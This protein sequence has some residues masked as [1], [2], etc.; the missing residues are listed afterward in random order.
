[1]LLATGAAAT[2]SAAQQQPAPLPRGA[3]VQPLGPD[4]GAELR[5][6]LTTLADNP[7]SLDALIGAGRAANESGDAEA[8]LSFFGRADELSPRNP[9]IK[10]G[11]AS[12]L[13]QM[14][15]AQAALNLF[16]QAIALGAPEAE[17]AGDRGLAYDMIG[18]PRR[19]QRD[20]TLALRR[21]DDAELRRRLALSL[22][23]SGQRDA[24]LRMID[25][26]LRRNDRAAWRTQAFVLALTGD[27][28]GATRTAQGTMPPG[29]AA[30]MAPFLA[31]LVVLSPAQKAMAV[32]F[33][34]FP[35][36]G[37]ARADSGVADTSADPGAVAL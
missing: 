3:V 24:A 27:A 18:D 15:R 35:S 14:G 13:V 29:A 8:A 32:H 7:R 23:I 37:R 20:Y 22:A 1:M 11:M 28:A 26:Q 31:R 4:N 16:A 6:H 12:A 33:G 36:D 30:A 17:I 34:H 25:P 10:A 21:R 2:P 5:R 19:A 9:R